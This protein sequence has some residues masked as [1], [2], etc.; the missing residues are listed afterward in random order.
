MHDYLI[1]SIME[2]CLNSD[3]HNIYAFA[4]IH[5]KNTLVAKV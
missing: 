1:G 4:I 2:P 5:T 3:M